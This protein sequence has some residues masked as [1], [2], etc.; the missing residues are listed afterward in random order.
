MHRYQISII[1]MHYRRNL[2]HCAVLPIY[3]TLGCVPLFKWVKMCLRAVTE[4]ISKSSWSRIIWVNGEK[5]FSEVRISDETEEKEEWIRFSSHCSDL[6]PFKTKKSIFSNPTKNS[7]FLISIHFDLFRKIVDD[8]R[9]APWLRFQIRGMK[10]KQWHLTTQRWLKRF[11]I[12]IVGDSKSPTSLAISRFSTKLFS[13]I[14]L[15]QI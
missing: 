5:Y 11:S 12:N 13:F 14:D 2:A 15:F 8:E 1:F 6:F 3:K 7:F 4:N 10:K 9:W